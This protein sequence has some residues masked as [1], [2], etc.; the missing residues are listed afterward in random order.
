MDELSLNQQE[1]VSSTGSIAESAAA[2]LLSSQLTN[3]IGKKI[4][5]DYIEV[6]SQGGFNNASVTLGKYITNKLFVSYEQ[7]IGQNSTTTADDASSY[8]VK[9]EYELFRFLF[10]QLNNSSEDSGFDL[11]YKFHSK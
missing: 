11:I 3:Y 8:E 9:L 10:F 1:N 4:N 6:K 2:S 5:L 7:Q